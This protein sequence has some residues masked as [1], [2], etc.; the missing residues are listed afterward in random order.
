MLDQA[1]AA[2][3][4]KLKYDAVNRGY[5]QTNGD[6]ARIATHAAPSEIDWTH[7]DRAMLDQAA[8]ESH[9]RDNYGIKNVYWDAAIKVVEHDALEKGNE[10][11]ERDEH[12]R[13]T[14]GGSEEPVKIVLSE[15]AQR[16]LAAR[17]PCNVEKQRTADQQEA[18]VSRALGLERTR[19]NSAFDFR[20]EKIAVEL[21][22]MVDAKND[23]ITMSKTALARK[24]NEQKKDALIGYTV[25]ADKRGGNTKYYYRAGF[26]SFRVGAMTPV[27]LADLRSII[28]GKNL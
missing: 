9:L 28:R 14:T 22:T 13:W 11:E 8:V 4:K 6:F 24:L 26:G 23:K 25:V 19:D 2:T 17:V 12:G 7:G 3:G 20:D 18:I 15:R 21:K 1:H 10:D 5:A 16:A 27:S